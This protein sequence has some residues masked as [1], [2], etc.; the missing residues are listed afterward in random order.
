[1]AY[2]STEAGKNNEVIDCQTRYGADSSS[3]TGLVLGTDSTEGN[4]AITNPIDT[5]FLGSITPVAGVGLMNFRTAAVA[6]ETTIQEAGLISGGV[7]D[8]RYELD[9]PVTVPIGSLAAIKL[10]ITGT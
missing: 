9:A 3:G 4:T 10:T 5:T 7:L 1:M 8:K 2:G 6:A